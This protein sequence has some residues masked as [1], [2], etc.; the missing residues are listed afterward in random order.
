M[1]VSLSP[2]PSQYFPNPNNTGAPAA[3]FKLFTYIAGTS[4]KQS[5]WTDST[6]TVTNANPLPLDA[7]GF[8][9]AASSASVWLDPTL[10]YKFVWAPANDTDPPSS[11]IRSVDNIRG[12]IDLAVLTQALI[13][14]LLYP[15]TDAEIAASQTPSNY[16]YPPIDV[17]RFGAVGDGVTVNTTALQNILNVAQYAKMRVHFPSQN[18]G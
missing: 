2:V 12:P 3:G 14:S 15:R 16:A 17:T 9:A 5:T 11:P 1:S 8:A 10:V 4:T 18:R 7:N 13:G 6:Q